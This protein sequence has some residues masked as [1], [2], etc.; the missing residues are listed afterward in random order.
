MTIV[1]LR[2]HWLL[3]LRSSEIFIKQE[4]G[5]LF[6]T[7][8]SMI[9]FKNSV[10]DLLESMP[11]PPGNDPGFFFSNTFSP[12]PADPSSSLQN[13]VLTDIA[14]DASDN[15]SEVT[16]SPFSPEVQSPSNFPTSYS[17]GGTTVCI[18]LHVHD[19]PFIIP[20]TIPSV[21]DAHLYCKGAYKAENSR[22]LG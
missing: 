3:P 19:R 2:L 15:W 6:P 22:L 17:Q 9:V 20:S 5:V 1:P 13:P 7:L 18:L 4:H 12:A 10:E 16:P 14:S 21:Y 11:C 8:P